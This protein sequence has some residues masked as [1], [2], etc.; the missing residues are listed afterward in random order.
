MLPDNVVLIT[1]ASSG[2][3]RAMALQLA[4]SGAR[5][6][7][8]AR[9][10]DALER[11]AVECREAGAEA[12]VVVA[13]VSV[14]A[15][16]ERLIREGVARYGRLDTLINNAGISMRARF[17]EVTDPL[18]FDTIMRVNYLGA[19]WCTFYAIPHLVKSR[20]RIVAVASLTGLTGVPLR[21]AYAASKHAMRGLFDS[22]R[23]ELA[24]T[25]VSVT[26]SY[27]GFVRSD[28]RRR[29]L[30]HDGAP[31]GGEPLDEEQEMSADECAALTL[32]AAVAR[33]RE[34]VM[35]LKGRVGLKVKAFAPALVDRIARAT[36]RRRKR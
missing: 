4:A 31:I 24:D 16:C 8:S 30:G 9:S 19:A 32:S 2:I 10:A 18:L 36:M 26:V 3:G 22:L 20:G 25:G 7:L 14:L 23:I 29:A 21:S 12:F 1:G 5:L 35:T 11:V 6:V 34:V 33:K 13:D 27:P 17:D 15:D 28:I